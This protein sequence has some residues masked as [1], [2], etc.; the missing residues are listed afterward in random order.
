MCFRS[1]DHALEDICKTIEEE[2]FTTLKVIRRHFLST[3]MEQLEMLSNE[4]WERSFR[5]K[6]I[7]EAGIDAGGL[8]REFFT[9]LFEKTDLLEG[10]SF[11]LKS[12][13]LVNKN[14]RLLGKA[15]AVALTYGHPG[16]KRFNSAVVHY[17]LNGCVPD[18]IEDKCIE[19]E[20]ALAAIRD[21]SS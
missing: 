3:A 6:F 2:K 16:P 17:I 11:Q 10:R 14:Y 18:T 19:R 21:V 15:T 20:D 4:E 5:V 12:D 8:R 7:G 13:Q 9:L 1:L